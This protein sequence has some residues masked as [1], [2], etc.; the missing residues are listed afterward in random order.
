MGPE[1]D[2]ERPRASALRILAV[3]VPVGMALVALAE[4]TLIEFA[5]VHLCRWPATISC[6]IGMPVVWSGLRWL[7]WVF[8]VVSAVDAMLFLGRPSA[9]GGRRVLAWALWGPSVVFVTVFAGQ[10]RTLEGGDLVL[11][12][13]LLLAGLAITG[14]TL[15]V[16]AGWPERRVAIALAPLILVVG[17]VPLWAPP[18][19]REVERRAP[20]W[21]DD[22]RRRASQ[23]CLRRQEAGVRK[24]APGSALPA[25]EIYPD[26]RASVPTPSR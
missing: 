13:L 8:V 2:A 16:R 24:A 4:S 10:D 19:F 22:A 9:E 25:C 3:A 12:A 11:G 14:R 17:T 20:L 21:E 23:E 5:G 6:E 7:L 18:A 15:A 26:P 1:E